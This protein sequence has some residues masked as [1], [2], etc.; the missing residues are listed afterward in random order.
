MYNNIRTNW[1][2]QFLSYYIEHNGAVILHVRLTWLSSCLCRCMSRR[3]CSCILCCSSCAALRAASLSS[4]L[5]HDP[6]SPSISSCST[7]R[8][9]CSGT[10]RVFRCLPNL[11][12]SYKLQ[13][14]SSTSL[15][16]QSYIVTHAMCPPPQQFFNTLA[17]L[18]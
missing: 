12:H 4:S 14:M 5:A 16:H 11:K 13:N 9:S 2:S 15:E 3:Y 6:S 8:A 18:Y 10:S 17:D 1:C 7:C